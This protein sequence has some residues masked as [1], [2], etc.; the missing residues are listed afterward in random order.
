M[1]ALEKTQEL[2]KQILSGSD[3]GKEKLMDALIALEGFSSMEFIQSL[4]AVDPFHKNPENKNL[5]SVAAYGIKRLLQ[6][7]AIESTNEFRFCPGC[8]SPLNRY[9]IADPYSVGLKCGN[10]HK[11]HVEIRQN[12]FFDKNLKVNKGGNIEVAKE[13]LTNEDYRKNVQSQVAE[14]L[15]KYIEIHDTKEIDDQQTVSY[16]YCPLCSLSLNKFKQDD[17]WVQGLKCRYGHSFYSRTGLSYK[18]ASL[19]P[20]IDKTT[21]KWLI[22]SYSSPEQKEHLPDQLVSLFNDIKENFLHLNSK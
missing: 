4:F 7:R 3:T 17:V 9:D 22:D 11:F 20:D 2:K 8:K 1:N 16:N 15:R 12:E 14:I 19:K 18:N 6:L 21:F 13:W 10:N 5:I